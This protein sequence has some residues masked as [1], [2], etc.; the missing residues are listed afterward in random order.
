MTKMWLVFLQNLTLDKALMLSTCNL[1]GVR[2]REELMFWNSVQTTV[3]KVGALLG[4]EQVKGNSNSELHQ[5]FF[6]LGKIVGTGI[7]KYRTRL[8]QC[9]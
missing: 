3:E 5:E 2:L 9:A 4:E 7:R 6:K 1:D 8:N